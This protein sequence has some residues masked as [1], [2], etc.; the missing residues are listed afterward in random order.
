MVKYPTLYARTSTGAVQVWFMEQDGARYRST[1][2][3]EDGKKVIAEWTNAKPKNVGRA[4]A[5]SAE[6][7]AKAEI[8]AKYKKQLKSGGYHKDVADIDIE[9]FFQVMLAKEYSKYKKKIDWSK[10]VGVQIKFNGGRIVAKKSGLF[11]RKG[12]RYI[13]IPHIEEGLKPFFIQWPKAIL[14]G[15][16]FNYKL[17]EKLNK[18]MKLL[19]KT[20]HATPK[21]LAKSK[22]MVRFYVYDGF[23]FG[24]VT[25]DDWYL[26]RQQA[27]NQAF[28]RKDADQY[29]NIIEPVETWIVYSEQ[30]LEALYK[31]FLEDKQEGAILR[32]LYVPYEEKRSKNLLKYK[33]VDDDEFRIISIQDG[34]GKFANRASTITCQLL[35]GK[36]DDD[37]NTF[38]AT[39]KGT[40]AQA[41]KFW[42]E[43]EKYIQKVVT[44]YFNGYTGKGKPNYARLD[45]NN[46]NKGH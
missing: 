46:W 42:K 33:P 4:N 2:G 6:E 45:Y 19:R 16:G 14:D 3:Q 23:N 35:K 15:E 8:D 34:D 22:E 30:E 12:E 25:K 39:F 7:Q 26:A 21:D 24:G 27:I 31:T 44:I 43:K 29:K 5:T 18:I 28:F 1:S 10:G 9:K 17:R 36:F 20:V 38:N 41:V 13:S 32:L 40:E 37:T 11:T